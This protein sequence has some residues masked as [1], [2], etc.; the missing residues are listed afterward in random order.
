VEAG[1]VRAVVT[2]KKIVLLSARAES[3][4]GL[5]ACAGEHGL[6]LGDLAQDGEHAKLWAPLLNVPDWPEVR[7]RLHSAVA[8]LE[9]EESLGLASVVGVEV[10]ARPELVAVALGALARRPRWLVTNAL[11]ISA[12]VPEADLDAV[13]RRWHDE[14]VGPPSAAQPS[15]RPASG[16]SIS[17]VSSAASR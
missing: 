4:A 8:E 1:A 7:Q 2:Q 16:A 5:L 9:I 15:S 12:V 10:G 11:R 14:L 6:P 17:P 13:A 3:V